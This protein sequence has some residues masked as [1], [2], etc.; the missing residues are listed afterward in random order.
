MSKEFRN[1]FLKSL[2]VLAPRIAA[3]IERYGD[4]TVNVDNITATGALKIVSPEDDS[5]YFSIA[6]TT[7]GATTINTVDEA[8]AAANLTLDVDGAF[9]VNVAADVTIDTAASVHI[10]S[11]EDIINAISLTSNSIY[12]NG[13]DQDDSYLF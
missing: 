1:E 4:E 7:N 11:T 6:T 12:F 5:D 3:A 8:A 10:T 2:N 13:G 9:D